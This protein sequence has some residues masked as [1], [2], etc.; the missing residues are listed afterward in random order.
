MLV[1]RYITGQ[2]DPHPPKVDNFVRLLITNVLISQN[3]FSYDSPQWTRKV[4]YWQSALTKEK[5][6]KLPG[7]WLRNF[8]KI[9]VTMHFPSNTSKNATS[10]LLN[11]AS[12]SLY[13]ALY[14]GEENTWRA[15]L[16]T[17]KTPPNIDRGCL[18]QGFNPLRQFRIGVTSQPRSFCISP[19]LV[20]GVGI[21]FEE[22]Q[23][24]SCGELIRKSNVPVEVYP[25][26]CRVYIQ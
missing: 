12:P 4:P 11:H 5:E 19:Y 14:S 17:V 24:I 15:N 6:I 13:S 25:A 23:K 3:T 18:M 10:I 7:Y 8:T 22:Y 20:R 2:P 9:C 16:S 26:F 21:R 1:H